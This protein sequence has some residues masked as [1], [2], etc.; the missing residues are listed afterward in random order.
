MCALGVPAEGPRMGRIRVFVRC[1]ESACRASRRGER[2]LSR[3]YL[4]W[5]VLSRQVNFMTVC[6]W[7]PSDSSTERQPVA[8]ADA[9]G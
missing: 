5:K 8:T 4:L 6:H 9:S 3:H 1:G 7:V 2:C